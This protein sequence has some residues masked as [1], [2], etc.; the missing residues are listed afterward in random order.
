MPA[1][2]I[3]RVDVKNRDMYRHYVDI[4]PSIIKKYGGTV[5]ARSEEPLTFEGPKETR[6]IIL[7]QFSALEKAQEFY[8]SPEYQ[9]ARKLREG[10]A[11]GEIIVVD[12]IVQT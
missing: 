1:Y 5:I 10:A 8:H 4:V 9:S 2:F 7:I 11:I 3:A 12:G 6:K